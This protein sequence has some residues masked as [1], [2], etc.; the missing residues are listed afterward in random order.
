MRLRPP[1]KYYGGKYYLTP[2]IT[3]LFCQHEVYLEPF[4]GAASVLLNKP[5]SKKEIYGDLNQNTVNLMRFIQQNNDLLTTK[6]SE[7]QCKEEV[8]YEWKKKICDNELDSA[9]KTFVIHRMSRGGVGGSFS[10]SNRSYRGM[11][12]NEASWMSGIE[13]L[14]LIS[15]RL[16]QVEITCSPAIE[17]M[18]KHEGE[19]SLFYLDPPYMRKLRSTPWSVYSVEMDDSQHEELLEFVKN[20]KSK[21]VISGYPSELYNESL[22]NWN[23]SNKSSFLHSGHAS[24]KKKSVECVWKNF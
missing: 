24:V 18:K 4:G 5:I 8:F 19:K 23:K 13:N 2:W 16:Q 17:L 9:I 14:N 11:S 6:L 15:S 10:K 12:E 3:S 1:F 7:I 20:N 22:K 21:I